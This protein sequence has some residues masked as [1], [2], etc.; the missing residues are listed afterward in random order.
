MKFSGS[1][2]PRCALATF[3]SEKV[4][5]YSS[6]KGNAMPLHNAVANLLLLPQLPVA[7]VF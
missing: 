4:G 5:A 1:A 7:V 3:C 6:R 2:P